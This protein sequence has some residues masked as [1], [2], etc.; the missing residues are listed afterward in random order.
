MSKEEIFQL[1]TELTAEILANAEAVSKSLSQ[2]KFTK[3]SRAM[4]SYVSRAGYVN[5]AILDCYASGNGYAIGIQFRAMIE[6]TFRHLYLYT[7]SLNDDSDEVGEEYY[8]K[9]KGSEDLEALS[10]ISNYT[11]VVHP[12]R[13]VW[14]MKG[15]HNA[16]ISKVGKKFNLSK[17]FFYMI[18]NFPSDEK[19]IDEGMKDYL[20]K[21]LNHYTQLS[22]YVHGGPYAEISHEELLKD[23][24]KMS[25]HMEVITRES[26]GLYKS[27]VESTFLFA[28]LFDDN[29][30]ECFDKVSAI[31][32][33]EYKNY[34][35]KR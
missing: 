15:D 10:K 29:M 26:F 19:M 7:R 4:L 28:Y 13:T 9:L 30:K 17:I 6:H 25:Q 5:N 21:R 23:R 1:N 27:I 32:G 18:E 11:K 34:E 33:N 24:T 14:S 12:E 20:L 16:Q 35:S 31:G 3:T 2:T 22:S 8:G